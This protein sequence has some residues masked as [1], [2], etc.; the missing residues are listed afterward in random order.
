MV[1]SAMNTRD[2]ALQTL[3]DLLLEGI[4]A[5]ADAWPGG[6]DA[7]QQV[8]DALAV[9]AEPVRRA[10]LPEP[11][12]VVP[13][14][15]GQA[16]ADARAAGGYAAAVGEALAQAMP[17]ITWYLRE[18]LT[19][20][21]EDFADRHALATL[22][23][24]SDR[25]GVL[26][27]RDDVRVGISLVAPRTEYPDHRHPPEEL[28]LALTAGEWRQDLGPWFEP[29]PGGVVFNTSNILHGMRAGASPQLALWCL[30]S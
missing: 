28:Y 12:P 3:L 14:M 27:V 4:A 26:E 9:V 5:R 17:Q 2:P 24:P 13:A 18:G 11:P 1:P 21:C 6:T 25:L 23:G 16:L 7:L 22:I 20:A 29:G 19:A 15:L 8:R 30:P 10:S